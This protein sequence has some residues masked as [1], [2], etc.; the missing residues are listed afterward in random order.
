MSG[1]FAEFER[2]REAVLVDAALQRQLRLTTDRES[3][4]ELLVALGNERG[5]RFTGPDVEDAL[6]DA[7]RTWIERWI[8]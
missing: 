1:N 6:R 8:D 2:F 4:I 3:F 7:R 5:Y